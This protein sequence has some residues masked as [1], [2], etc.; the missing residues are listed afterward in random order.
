MAIRI[1]LR[2]AKILTVGC[3]LSNEGL[4][5]KI[6]ELMRRLLTKVVT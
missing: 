2:A 3:A 5:L 6:T 1:H 4:E